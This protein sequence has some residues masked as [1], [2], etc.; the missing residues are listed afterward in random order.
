MNKAHPECGHGHDGLRRCVW[1]RA[2]PW[3]GVVVI[4]LICLALVAP[5]HTSTERAAQAPTGQI[6]GEGRRISLN[7]Q[8]IEVRA[9]LQLIADFSQFN[10]I[11][12]DAVR[13]R[14]T[15]R[16]RDLPWE[17]ALQTI[18]QTRDLTMVQQGT[19]IW[20]ATREELATR[21]RY[22]LEERMAIERLE[23]LVTRSFQLHYARAQEVV[24][25]L[26]GV[27]H[28]QS[29][30]LAGGVPGHLTVRLLLQPGARP[31]KA[32]SPHRIIGKESK[33]PPMAAPVR[34]A[35]RQPPLRAALL[36]RQAPRALRVHTAAAT[37]RRACRTCRG[38]VSVRAAPQ[39]AF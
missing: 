33:T 1:A 15:V 17:Q 21:Q 31:G 39:H 16:M 11:S 28:L 22:A 27:A 9:L 36:R 29:L 32:G 10:I 4:G 7:F 8:D 24:A 12:S 34:Q 2:R 26:T 13:G 14:I 25:Q 6:S 3:W 38:A 30:A 37:V 5:G 23:P 20:V 35:V 19:V 18:L